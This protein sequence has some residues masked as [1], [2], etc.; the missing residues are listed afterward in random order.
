MLVDDVPQCHVQIVIV[1]NLASEDIEDSDESLGDSD[2]A[3]ETSP[4][5]GIRGCLFWVLWQIGNVYDGCFHSRVFGPFHRAK[6]PLYS[7]L[8]V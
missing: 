3:S 2:P 1:N 4:E 6:R 5:V 8:Y 7:R